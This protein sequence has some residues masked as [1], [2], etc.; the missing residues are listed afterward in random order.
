VFERLVGKLSVRGHLQVDV[1]VGDGPEQTA[2]LD[3]PGDEDRAAVAALQ[4]CGGGIE[5]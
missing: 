1:V 5:S 4:D 2:I 3:V